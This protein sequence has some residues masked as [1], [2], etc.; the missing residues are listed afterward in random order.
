[1][2]EREYRRSLLDTV[3]EAPTIV[4]QG[5]QGERKSCDT[6]GNLWAF[7]VGS[8][9]TPI[10]FIFRHALCDH[11]PSAHRATICR[12]RCLFFWRAPPKFD[13][14]GTCVNLGRL[15]VPSSETFFVFHVFPDFRF[16]ASGYSD[17]TSS[18]CTTW[19][20]N[21]Q[22]IVPRNMTAQKKSWQQTAVCSHLTTVR[23]VPVKSAPWPSETEPS[24]ATPLSRKSISESYSVWL[25]LPMATLTRA[26]RTL[27]DLRSKSNLLVET[28]I[29][30]YGLHYIYLNLYDQIFA[31]FWLSRCYN[32]QT[33]NSLRPGVSQTAAETTLL[34]CS[35]SLILY[36]HIYKYIYTPVYIYIYIYIH[37][38]I[39]IYISIY[40]YIYI[41]IIYIYYI[42]IHIYTYLYICIYFF[43]YQV[44]TIYLYIYIY[45]MTHLYVYPYLYF[46]IFITF[47]TWTRS[48]HDHIHV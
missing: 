18:R 13:L 36:I 4:A 16:R 27:S 48:F 35:A 25:S 20:S 26:R 5:C 12:F 44:C 31:N 3:R 39:R 11:I 6:K 41:D 33:W 21:H 7:G 42:Y 9:T 34:L 43:K 28:A 10:C 29:F 2:L 30:H 38:Y 40:M 24:Q 32:N 14:L 1:V 37:T 23:L 45:I 15:V 46:Y 19:Q 22:C 8:R 17:R 47:W